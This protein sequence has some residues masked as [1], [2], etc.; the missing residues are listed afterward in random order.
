MPDPD[1]STTGAYKAK[2][3]A[4]IKP[5]KP[6][7]RM[8]ASLGTAFVVLILGVVTYVSLVRVR[9][10]RAWVEHSHQTIDV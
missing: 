7:A 9:D 2:E 4:L 6:V 5:L 10:S 8:V 1:S 3:P